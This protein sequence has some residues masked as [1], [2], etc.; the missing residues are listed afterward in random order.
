MW[1]EIPHRTFVLALAAWTGL[2]LLPSRADT[3]LVPVQ[4]PTIQAAMIDEPKSAGFSY[5][6]LSSSRLSCPQHLVSV[7]QSTICS[8]GQGQT[9]HPEG[10]FPLTMSFVLFLLPKGK[11]QFPSPAPKHRSS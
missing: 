11:S 5:C 8:R 7:L 3:L 2:G 10:V 1:P 4:Y 9:E 6:C